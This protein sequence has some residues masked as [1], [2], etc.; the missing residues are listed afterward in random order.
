MGVVGV[1]D[2]CARV[3]VP[4]VCIVYIVWVFF[5][6][7]WRWSRARETKRSWA[8]IEHWLTELSKELVQRVGENR[9][10][11]G[12]MPGKLTVCFTEIQKVG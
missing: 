12:H 2:T 10:V 4:C 7:R 9:Q 6:F 8:E 1:C 3:R 5:F 11:E